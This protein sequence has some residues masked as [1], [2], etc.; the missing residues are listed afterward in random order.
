MPTKTE[1]TINW[2]SGTLY[3]CPP[4]GGDPVAVGPVKGLTETIEQEHL[5]DPFLPAPVTKSLT[6][7]FSFE[8]E[9]E[10]LSL[11]KLWRLSGDPALFAKWALTKHPHLAYLGAFAKTGRRRTKNLR[12]L[13]HMFVEE[14][15]A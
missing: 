1:N 11:P 14:A 8:A 10:A 4:E 15:F 5:D 2:G 12:R 3:Y 7:T 9:L 6:Q 13:V